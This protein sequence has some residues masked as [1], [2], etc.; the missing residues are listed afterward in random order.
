MLARA[1][2]N[3]RT[4]DLCINIAGRRL[5]WRN[6]NH[7]VTLGRDTLRWN[8][9][10]EANDAAYG[11]IAAVHL[12]SAGLKVVADR[13]TITLADGRA[14]QIVNTDPG[15][16]SSSERKAL[17]RDFVRDLHSRLAAARYPQIRFTEGWNLWRCQAVLAL[18]TLVRSFRPRSGFTSCCI[19]AS[20]AASFS[21][22]WRLTR[23]GSS[24]APRSTTRRAT[25]RRTG[26]R[27]F[28]CR[29]AR[30]PSPA[31]AE[32]LA[33]PAPQLRGWGTIR[34]VAKQA[35]DGE[36]APPPSCLASLTG[37][38]PASTSDCVTTDFYL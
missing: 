19:L 26:C 16:Y 30:A 1:A 35:K 11:D 36:G 7:G 6:R 8:M 33:Y 27:S 2:E 15:G 12:D 31:R 29:R 10:G 25:T 22:R 24:T 34:S 32:A 5:Y 13:C 18:T 38:L 20:R 14:L 9:D 4:Y 37:P 17:Y 3:P 28:C 23:A 21:S